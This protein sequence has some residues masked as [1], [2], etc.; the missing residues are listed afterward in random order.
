MKKSK[1]F[2]LVEVIAVIGILSLVL[3]IAVPKVKSYIRDRKENAFILNAKNILRELEYQNIEGTGFDKKSLSELNL[4]N[5]PNGV[6]DLEKSCV[7]MNDSDIYI[8]LIGINKYKG[9]NVCR[10]NN[11]TTNINIQDELCGQLE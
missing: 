10:I 3:T 6:F 2:T 7:Y 5:I 1:G 11:F 4:K 9:M 8:N